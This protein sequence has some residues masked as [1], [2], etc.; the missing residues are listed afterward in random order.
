M[1]LISCVLSWR[2]GRTNSGLGL[3][4]W[5]LSKYTRLINLKLCSLSPAVR[6]HTHPCNLEANVKRRWV[7]PESCLLLLF[8]PGFPLSFIS[9]LKSWFVCHLM[10]SRVASAAIESRLSRR[11]KNQ[12][13]PFRKS[14]SRYV[15]HTYF[16]L[17]FMSLADCH[18]IH[19]Q[20]SI[21]QQREGLLRDISLL[22]Q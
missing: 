11:T 15:I 18:Q 12:Q 17:V 6:I 4:S 20:W 3:S 1:P 7:R 21:S 8:E 5:F 19:G 14:N 10:R 2:E 22:S 9:E 16:N 13:R